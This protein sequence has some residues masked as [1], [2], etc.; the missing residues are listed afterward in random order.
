MNRKYIRRSLV[1][2]SDPELCEL[3][4][5]YLA[6]PSVSLRLNSPALGYSAHVEGCPT[7]A[8]APNRQALPYCIGNEVTDPAIPATGN[9][10]R[11]FHECA[12]E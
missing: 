7:T 5:A 4:I 11:N 2:L 1:H 9:A 3:T 10:F 12:H 6:R 8:P